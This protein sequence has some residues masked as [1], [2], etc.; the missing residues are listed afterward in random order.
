MITFREVV[1]ALLILSGFGWVMV[2]VFNF[3]F[4]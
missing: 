3:L 4:L 2:K 1:V